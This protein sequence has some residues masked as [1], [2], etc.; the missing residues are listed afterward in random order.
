MQR[1]QGE[2][3]NTPELAPGILYPKKRRQPVSEAAGVL[4]V[5]VFNCVPV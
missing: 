4:T 3:L 2:I 5:F 1:F